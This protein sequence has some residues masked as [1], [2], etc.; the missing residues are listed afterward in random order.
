MMISFDDIET[1]AGNASTFAERP[2]KR[3]VKSQKSKVKRQKCGTHPAS[4][5]NRRT[6]PGSYAQLALFNFCLLIFAF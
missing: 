5:V 4:L 2:K 1:D 6:G 3:Q